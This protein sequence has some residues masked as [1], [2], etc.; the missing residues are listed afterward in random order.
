V[1]LRPAQ[2]TAREEGFVLIEILVST[3]VLIIASAGV[4]VLLQTTT[5][6]Q[7]ELRHN[8]EAYALAQEDQARLASMRL[9]TLNRLDQTRTVT[10]NKT[11]FSVRSRGVFIND[12][13]SKPTCGE[14][15]SS[16]DYVEITS[17]VSWPGM[18]P[19]EKAKIVS[20]LSPSNGSLDPNNGTIAFSVV[21]QNQA[22]VPNVYVTGGSGAFAGYTDASGCAVFSDLPA[23]N[24]TATLSGEAAG[25]VNHDGE[26]TM[27]EKVPVAG[28]D[29]QTV[30]F[31]FDRPGTIPVK[32][33]YREGTSSTYKES[34]AASVVAFNSG[35]K[36]AKVFWTADGSAQ[37]AVEAKPLF[38]FSS[39]YFIYAGSCSSNNP[40][41]KGEGKNPSAVANVAAPAGGIAL[42]PQIQLPAYDPTVWSGPNSSNKGSALANADVWVRDTT[43]TNK[44]GQL[45]TRRY[46]TNSLGK[47]P[48]LG[49]PWGTYTVCADTEPGSLTSGVRRQRLASPVTVQNLAGPTTSN[50]YLGTGSGSVYESGSCP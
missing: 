28:G 5:H 1:R 30:T 50:F 35:M 21:T 7:A 42:A 3:M 49:L 23:G 12:N 27:Q 25:V 22:P 36:A 9:S 48:D 14:G 20:I 24:Y 10:L 38:P 33:K 45:V 13:T 31:E 47:L 18:D 43:C 8:S 40:D 15:T 32:F 6:S 39:T 19:G 26:S 46:T 17:S 2:N 41:P 44:S 4:M 29:T 11:P 37:S 16:A 34:S